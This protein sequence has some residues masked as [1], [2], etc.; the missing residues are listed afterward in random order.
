MA[1]FVVLVLPVLV[2][3][4]CADVHLGD[5]YGKKTRAVFQAQA[6]APGTGE[7]M[8]DAED[9]RL[10]LARHRNKVQQPGAA[11]YGGATFQTPVLV[12]TGGGTMGA[13]QGSVVAP[14]K[15][16]SVR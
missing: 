7:G 11:G 10:I 1:R 15:L 8:I 4:A 16:E 9:A 5:D 3:G 13:G 2:L 12:G 14:I 6:E